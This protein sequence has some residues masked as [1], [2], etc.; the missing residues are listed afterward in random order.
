MRIGR[1]FLFA[2]LGTALLA[3]AA[4]ARLAKRRTTAPATAASDG[5]VEDLWPPV[6][7][8]AEG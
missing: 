3:I 6:P 5:T 2:F 7:R 8:R 1:L 4:G